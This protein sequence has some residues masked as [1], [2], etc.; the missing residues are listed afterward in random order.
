[1]RACLFPFLA[2]LLSAPLVAAADRTVSLRLIRVDDTIGI[3]AK[4]DFES[5]ASEGRVACELKRSLNDKPVSCKLADDGLMTFTDPERKDEKVASATIPA[6]LQSV[7]LFFYQVADADTDD[8]DTVPGGKTPEIAILVVDD[9]VEAVPPGCIFV[10][11]LSDGPT[12]FTAGDLG[13]AEVAV[14]GSAVLGKGAGMDRAG[15]VETHFY[16]RSKDSWQRAMS[17]QL[18]LSNWMRC[19]TLSYRLPGRAAPRTQAFRQDLPLD[20]LPKK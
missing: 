1:M 10:A 18:A 9:S 11:N 5:G 16:F 17:G 19:F 6:G 13:V 12:R 20:P 15:K 2:L 4:L 3:P 7:I 8:E 14:G